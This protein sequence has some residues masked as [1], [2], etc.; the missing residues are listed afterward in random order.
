MKV[1]GLTR[2]RRSQRGRQSS[3]LGARGWGLGIRGSGLRACLGLALCLLWAAP[4][5]FAQEA[6]PVEPAVEPRG[7][8]ALPWLTD[9]KSGHRQALADG[10]PVLVR[11]GAEWC[12]VCRRLEGEIQKADVQAELARWTLVYLDADRSAEDLRE[13]NVTAVPALRVRTPGGQLLESRDGDLSA[14]E[15]AAWLKEH[16]AAAVVAPDAVL[17]G[18][19]EPDAAT[20]TR[21]VRQFDQRDPVVREAAVRR[22]LSHPQAA[23]DAVVEEFREGKLAVRLAALELLRSWQ[24]PVDELDPWRPE[25]ITEQR[26][27]AL[28]EWLKTDI[29]GWKSAPETL[30]DDQ[31]ESLRQ[32][33]DRMLKGTDEEAAAA[34]ARLAR[35]GPALLPEVY[36]RLKQAAT[37][38]DRQRLLA[39]RYRLVADDALVLRW[40]GGLVR[41]AATDSTQRQEA[42]EELAKLATVRDQQLLLELFSDP[43]P[44]VREI[45]LRGLQNLGG[46]EATAALVQLLADPE[47]NVR[48]AVLKQLEGN[49]QPGMVPKIAEYVKTEQDPDLIVHAIRFL[50]AAGGPAAIKSLIPLLKHESWQVRAEA[51]AGVGG[52]D[53]S[54]ATI[55]DSP[56]GLGPFDTGGDDDPSANLHADAIAALVELLDDPDAFVV[57]RAIEGLANSDMTLAVDPLIRAAEKHPDLTLNI[58]EMLAGNGNLREEALPHLRA[59]C[60]HADPMIRAAAIRGLTYAGVGAFQDAFQDE[61]VAGLEDNEAIVRIAAAGAVFRLLQDHRETGLGQIQEEANE[62]RWEFERGGVR[63][64]PQESLATRLVRALAGSAEPEDAEAANEPTVEEKAPEVE[65]APAEDDDAPAKNDDEPAEEESFPETPADRWLKEYHAGSH[66]P[67]WAEKT[68]APLEKMLRAEDAEERMTAAVTLVAL[69]RA[70]VGLPV[71]REVVGSQPD[72]LANATQVF[73]WLVWEERLRLFTFLRSHAERSGNESTLVQAMIEVPDRRAA[74]L[75]WTML[76]EENVTPQTAYMLD[77]G[78]RTAYLGEYYYSASRVI[79]DVRREMAAA[80]KAR[81][82]SGGELQRLT[83]LS[84]LA[85][86]APD[87]AAEVAGRLADDAQLGDQLRHDAFRVMLLTQQKGQA[88]ATAIATLSGEDAQRRQFA[89]IYLTGDANQLGNFRSA[90]YLNID[91]PWYTPDRNTGEFILPEPPPGLE[92]AHVRPLIDDPDPQIAARAGYLLALFDEPEGLDVLLRYWNGQGGENASISE[93]LVYRAIAKLDDSSQIPVLRKIYEGFDEYE[94]SEFYWTIRI[95]SGREIL[96]FRDKIREDVGGM[97]NLR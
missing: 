77:R 80:A 22:L 16:Y 4:V 50:R 44:L 96:L 28:D 70:D 14:E 72:L 52:M 11:V 3:G 88:I 97:Q 24:A 94:V 57:S 5:L 20:V 29:E 48:A 82:T 74:S 15:L 47:P 18:S 27:A 93:R 34:R 61:L 86:A 92:A 76:A 19:G 7:P 39:L 84:L 46:S 59:F 6:P 65:D 71:L 90:F 68:V 38:E 63:L 31:L 43:D 60:K 21:L 58:V 49:P 35:W 54:F 85:T 32:Q 26:L 1:I 41:L 55:G 87:E 53:T 56:S 13:L 17:L 64:Q 37:D 67:A 36:Q 10:R 8:Q 91:V 89:L 40:P 33:I 66:R 12:L 69:A 30:S 42:A 83:A 23:R 45:S 79:E 75:F 25:S 62:I 95:M 81:A 51:A 78:L 9:L 73:P 2:H